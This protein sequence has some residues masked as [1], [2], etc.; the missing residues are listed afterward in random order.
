MRVKISVLEK[1]KNKGVFSRKPAKNA[2][3]SISFL[4]NPFVT[5]PLKSATSQI[6]SQK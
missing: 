5:I 4:F 2:P 6:F 3:K 1:Y